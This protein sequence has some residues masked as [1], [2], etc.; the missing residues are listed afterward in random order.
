MHESHAA[1]I[2]GDS[3]FLA[4]KAQYTDLDKMEI[5]QFAPPT[6]LAPFVTQIY[7]FS[8]EES[9]IR[10]VQ[11]AALGH[12]VFFLRGSGNLRFQDGHV[13]P[14][15]QVSVFGPCNAAAEF[16]L[17]G[18]FTNFGLA[19]TPL[20]FVALTGKPANVYADRLVDA[21]ELFGPEVTVLAEEFCA[22]TRS[23]NMRHADLV[24]RVSAFLLS[25]ARAVPAAHIALIQTVANWISSEFDPDVNA[26]LAQINM[27]R[28][29]ATRL[30]V[31]YFGTTPKPLMRKYRAVRAASLLCDPN[32]TPELR[33]QI[34]S[35]FYDQPH[36]IREIRH[37]VGRTP[38]ALDGDDAKILR[39]WLSK[40]NYRD[41]ELH[42]G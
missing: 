39:I 6:E 37:F 1:G 26:L 11:P 40:D 33:M 19:L 41:L 3:E 5:L 15:R 30:I 31:R 12:L 23:G 8:C 22:L 9:Y 14:L 38:G 24:Q 13:D 16:T 28:S 32:C 7:F 27:S 21:A 20:G 18:P 42:P 4:D 17:S 25:R 36:M 34:E 35:L 2:A 10:E 29:T